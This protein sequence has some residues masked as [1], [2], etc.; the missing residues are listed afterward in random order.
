[1]KRRTDRGFTLMELMVVMVIIAIIAGLVMGVAGITIQKGNRSRAQGEIAGIT[2]SA[3]RY[4]TDNG[5]Y[6]R[7]DGITEDTKGQTPPIDPR[8]DGDPTARK[9]EDASQFLY[10]QLAGDSLLNG[11]P[12]ANGE[13]NYMNF[14]PGMIEKTGTGAETRILYVKDPFGHSYG[15]STMGMR[16][17]EL[18]KEKAAG[19]DRNV[20][21]K[22]GQARDTTNTF[23]YNA[24][25]FDLWSTA[26]Q[27]KAPS[28]SPA[29][30]AKWVKNW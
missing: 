7:Q 12:G 28:I 25:I 19:A 27:K 15:Y 1:M 24:G 21:T 8:T 18:Y 9:Y 10:G 23:G 6:P 14:T 11:K 5:D 4:K 26:G 13:K 30:Q 29:V 20:D 16:M 17:E 3:E 2:A 22:K